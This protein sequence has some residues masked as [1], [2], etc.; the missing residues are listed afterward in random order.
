MVRAA[1]RGGP[2]LIAER[3]LTATKPL[4]PGSSPVVGSILPRPRT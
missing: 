1:H 3:L 4:L 2:G